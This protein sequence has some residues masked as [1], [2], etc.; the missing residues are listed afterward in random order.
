V[1]ELLYLMFALTSGITHD[2]KRAPPCIRLYQLRMPEYSDGE[3]MRVQ[4]SRSSSS[5]TIWASYSG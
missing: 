2:P 5:T 3:K 1:L 4:W